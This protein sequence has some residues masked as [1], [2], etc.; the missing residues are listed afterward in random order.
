MLLNRSFYVINMLLWYYN[1]PKG[2]IACSISQLLEHRT[3]FFLGASHSLILERTYFGICAFRS[4]QPWGMMY[5]H[6]SIFLWYFS[7]N[8]LSWAFYV[9][10][11]QAFDA[12][13]YFRFLTTSWTQMYILIDALSLAMQTRFHFEHDSILMDAQSVCCMNGAWPHRIF[14]CS[15]SAIDSH[16]NAMAIP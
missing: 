11:L 6:N 1:Y 12:I 16:P 5:V 9:I 13:L 10:L 2:A 3:D 14:F 4:T 8:C 15:A 7:P